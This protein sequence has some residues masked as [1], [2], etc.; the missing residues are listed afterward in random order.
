MWLVLNV[1]GIWSFC[2]QCFQYFQPGLISFL[3]LGLSL[4]ETKSV[5][6]E[7][8]LLQKQDDKVVVNQLIQAV[9]GGTVDHDDLQ[10]NQ[11]LIRLAGYLAHSSSANWLSSGEANPQKK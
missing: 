6:K 5:I 1:I 10:D 4:K 8:Q 9:N 11:E 7:A 3:L 2:I